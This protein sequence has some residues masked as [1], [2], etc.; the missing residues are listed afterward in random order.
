MKLLALLVPKNSFNFTIFSNFFLWKL[1]YLEM[2]WVNY[3]LLEKSISFRFSNL[4][5]VVQKTF[6]T[7][8]PFFISFFLSCI[9]FYICSFFLDLW[10]DFL[11]L[12]MIQV[13][14]YLPC[15]P[16]PVI[17][18]INSFYFYFISSA[19]LWFIALFSNSLLL[20]FQFY[21]FNINISFTWWLR[22]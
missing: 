6:K 2:V 1:V 12:P 21:P 9:I 13:Y 5:E 8:L 14:T 19:F 16:T 3:I 4:D 17:S 18:L 11:S 22:E 10:E 15:R 20:F 7:F